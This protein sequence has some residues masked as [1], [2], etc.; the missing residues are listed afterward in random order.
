MR[1]GI[2]ALLSLAVPGAGQLLLGRWL[3]A[4]LLLWLALWLRLLLA[5]TAFSLHQ[6]QLAVD[7]WLVGAAALPGGDLRPVA[8]VFTVAAAA[9][10]LV[11][12]LDA[13]RGGQ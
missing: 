6:P 5:G 2:A 3:P 1:H 7:A 8:V 11:A 9:V 4:V 10:H 12:A 13:R